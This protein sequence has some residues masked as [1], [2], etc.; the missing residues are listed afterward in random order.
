MQPMK[1]SDFSVIV[2]FFALAVTG[3]FL[4]PQLPVKLTPER[5]SHDISIHCSYPGMAAAKVEQDVSLKLEGVIATLP[6]VKNIRTVSEPGQCDISVT[7][8]ENVNIREAKLE[9]STLIRQLHKLLPEGASYPIITAGGS[10]TDGSS[11]ILS[12]TFSGPGTARELA[13]YFDKRILPAIN[14]IPCISKVVISGRPERKLVIRY[15]SEKISNHGMT[16]ETISREISKYIERQQLGRVTET[17]DNGK[18]RRVYLSVSNLVDGNT[19]RWQQIPVA[20]LNGH[21]VLLGE[22]A[23]V[24]MEDEEGPGT[25]RI[26]AHQAITIGL[27]SAGYANSLH[28]EAASAEINAMLR[29]QLPAG[30]D[31]ILQENSVSLV[32][33]TLKEMIWR[34][35]GIMLAA[36]LSGMLLFRGYRYVFV[37]LL[38][39]LCIVGIWSVIAYALHYTL[40]VPLMVGLCI[41]LIFSIYGVVIRMVNSSLVRSAVLYTLV[42]IHLIVISTLLSLFVTDAFVRADIWDIA[43]PLITY[44]LVSLLSVWLFVPALCNKLQITVRRWRRRSY[45]APIL[46]I[47]CYLYLFYSSLYRCKWLLIP[48]GVLFFGLPLFLLPQYMQPGQ[49]GAGL[50][51]KTIGTS[52]YRYTIRPVTDKWL[53]GTLSQFVNQ[54]MSP[55]AYQR[56]DQRT[57]LEISISVPV[58]I[59][60]NRLV[61]VTGAFESYLRDMPQLEQFSTRMKGDGS[62]QMRIVFKD[63]YAQGGFPIYLKSR[64]EEKAAQTGLASFIITGLGAGFSNVKRNELGNYMIEVAGYNYRQL[65]AIAADIREKLLEQPRVKSAVV[66]NTHSNTERLGEGISYEFSFG[67]M[68]NTILRDADMQ[69]I[70]RLN[71]HNSNTAR[72]LVSIPMEGQ[73]MP[74]V[75]QSDSSTTIELWNL[76]HSPIS[77]DSAA[78]LRLS[79]QGGIDTISKS[80]AIVRQN[81]QYNQVVHYT[82]LGDEHFGEYFRDNMIADIS[83]D[84]PIGYKI[85]AS[86]SMEALQAARQLCAALLLAMVAVFITGSVV[87]NDL[88]QPLYITLIVLFSFTGVFITAVFLE[89]TFNECAIAFFLCSGFVAGGPLLIT[90]LYSGLLKSHGNRWAVL[91]LFITL[92]RTALPVILSAIFC[93]GGFLSFWYYTSDTTNYLKMV[94]VAGSI[95]IALPAYFLFLPV[96]LAGKR[97]YQQYNHL[98]R[99]KK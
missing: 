15:S 53:G 40:T 80:S 87:L 94:C 78:W 8:D 24:A 45:T 22:V 46:R 92:R 86:T 69:A 37:L 28:A 73:L 19:I 56:K 38:S 85:A 36:I 84:L 79:E 20:V 67:M 29:K 27:I 72:T 44:T 47:P 13:T 76:L 68:G 70:A 41:G 26:N 55:F 25:L 11:V 42:G 31:L 66:R 62:A 65:Y 3:Y 9:I 14:S 93:A 96:C 30:Y 35:S 5:T 32:R 99:C 34:I 97:I 82:L 77:K 61:A 48:G 33:N 2:F 7:L 43:G 91:L 95:L 64:L 58:G 83:G 10:N 57:Q 17:D 51:N 49:P 54:Q 6:E 59:S 98:Q 81:Q 63:A 74:V 60:D 71:G 4:L 18:D 88:R 1:V 23:T 75:L 16:S 90:I 12:Y 52:I 50:Y 89:V 39:Q 21:T